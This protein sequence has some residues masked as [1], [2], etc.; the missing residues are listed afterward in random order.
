MTDPP[1]RIVGLMSGTSLDGMDAAL[2]EIVD[3]RN[4]KLLGFTTRPYS[5]AEQLRIRRA[6]EDTTAR[7]LALLH[8]ALGDWAVE[9]IEQLIQGGGN[10]SRAFD[11][12]A[13][14][15]Q[16]IWHEPP[17]V[18]WQLGDAAR[19]A[20]RFRVPVV[21]DFRARDVAAG[22]Q[23]APLV[24]L[25]DA[26][27]FSASEPRILLNLGGMA[28]ATWLPAGGDP[29]QVLAG[30]SGPG[31]AVIDALARRIDAS[32]KYDV[33]G[34]LAARGKVDWALLNGLLADPFFSLAP[35]RSTGREQFGDRYAE[36]L[37]AKLPGVDGVRTA[38][39]LT[40]RSVVD[41]CTGYLPGAP[42]VVVSGGGARHPVV[43]AGLRAALA[44]Q[45]MR[46]IHFEELF[47]SADAKE[48]VAFATLGWLTLQGCTGNLPAVTGAHAARILGSVVP[49]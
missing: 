16:T 11:A 28:N 8:A 12:I 39:E 29:S 38:V 5:N 1:G 21:H 45:G 37:S 42:E 47:F 4:A 49:S 23:G 26:L 24:P 19:V 10:A 6:M 41:F 40:V 17:L 34:R 22:G 13:F 27:L 43:M 20:E 30:D 9:A 25:I 3:S 32:L 36:R 46:L 33:E 18:T 7:E 48:A 44:A 35:P 2:V 14:P 15:G 31:M